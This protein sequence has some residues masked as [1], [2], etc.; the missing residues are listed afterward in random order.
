MNETQKTV[1]KMLRGDKCTPEDV[2]EHSGMTKEEKAVVLD[3]Y[4]GFINQELFEESTMELELPSND[5]INDDSAMYTWGT[6]VADSK[7]TPIQPYFSL[8]FAGKQGSGKTAFTFD[9]AIKNAKLGHKV[10]Y[11]SLEMSTKNI[12]TRI[13]ISTAKI[14]KAQWRDK[15]L[16]TKKQREIYF[17]TKEEIR[18][19]DN[20]VAE[21]IDTGDNPTKE[22]I[23]ERIRKTGATLAFVDNLD[24]VTTGRSSGKN[25]DKY[26]ET[27]NYF[28]R[29][30]NENRVPVILIHHTRKDGADFN[31]DDIRGSG[32]ITDDADGVF[33]CGRNQ[34][35]QEV[36]K[37]EKAKFCVAEAKDRLMGEFGFHVFYSRGGSFFDTYVEERPIPDEI[38]KMDANNFEF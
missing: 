36:D 1:L 8:I 23:A 29:F 15:S 2:R 28:L 13:A 22:Y 14:T 25:E 33:M 18:S 7:F 17:K 11:L 12:L 10:L 16:I 38:R 35:P 37:R 24:L 19:I 9:M 27:T 32:K 30:T 26:K 4:M 5:D 20:L 6:E 31:P 34:D 21:G 3:A